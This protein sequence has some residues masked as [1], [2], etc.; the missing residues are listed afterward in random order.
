VVG[1]VKR[2]LPG[3]VGAA[4][5]RDPAA[6]IGHR[7]ARRAAVAH[8]SA[9]QVLDRWDVEAPI[10]DP[11]CDQAT[12]RPHGQPARELDLDASVRLRAGVDDE[13]PDQELRPQ[14]PRLTMGAGGQ[15]GATDAIGEA[16]IVLDPRAR[17]RLAA[18]SM[19]LDDQCS[20]PLRGRVDRRRQACRP[21]AEDDQVVVVVLGSGGEARAG[22]ELGPPDGGGQIVARAGRITSPRG[23]FGVPLRGLEPAAV[24]EQRDRLDRGLDLPIREQRRQRIEVEVDPTERDLIALQ[25]VPR[26]LRGQLPATAKQ[27]HHVRPIAL[28]QRRYSQRPLGGQAASRAPG[29]RDRLRRHALAPRG[30]PPHRRRPSTMG[31]PPDFQVAPEDDQSSRVAGCSFATPKRTPTPPAIASKARPSP[32]PFAASSATSPAASGTSSSR[33][34]RPLDINLLT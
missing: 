32:R 1:E 13:N 33:P 20:Q 19:D 7:L 22:R 30:D 5:D 31:P 10:G 2:R 17:A 24:G 12:A 25:E 23:R 11:G 3:R 28:M 18:G 6:R 21:G 8:A 14:A 4:D 16:G 29:G 9:D 26:S 15:I 34:A 27:G